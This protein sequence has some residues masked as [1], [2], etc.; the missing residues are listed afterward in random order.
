M[1]VTTWAGFPVPASTAQY[2]MGPLF[3]TTTSDFVYNT[4]HADGTYT[5]CADPDGWHGLDFNTPV[6]QAGG[7]DGALIGPQSI[8]PRTIDV[9]A[10]VVAPTPQLLWQ[11]IK[12]VRD[13][14]AA[15]QPVIWEQYDFGAGL[16]L[17]MVT[18]PTGK[19]VPSPVFSHQA[20]GLAATFKYSLI[21][22]SPWKYLSGSGENA[23]VG[24]VN[25]ALITG[26][27]YDKT[28]SYTYG[29]SSTPGGVMQVINQ[30]DTAAYPLFTITGPVNFPTVTNVTTG[31]QF[32]VNA[33]IAAGSTVTVDANTG[34]V[35]PGNLRLIGRPFTLAP[36]PNTIRWTDASAA[37]DP[38]ATLRLDWRS[39]FK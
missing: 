15:K 1:P 7:R 16:T 28:Y 24:L 23:S 12:A 18:R 29:S 21:A 4:Q 26:R 25:P 34:A 2:R 19:L 37:Y 14:L 5:I 8:G 30:G 36:G 13:I 10:M 39:T 9:V 27:T 20:G 11:K 6:D 38:A 17:A 31:Q 35:S 3:T 32:Q 33:V 22:A